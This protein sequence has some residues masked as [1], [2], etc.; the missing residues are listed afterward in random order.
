MKHSA[1]LGLASLCLVGWLGVTPG[2]A[3]AAP[4][5]R[6]TPG[7][8]GSFEFDTGAVRGKLREDG[9]SKGLTAVIDRRTGSRI[10][11]GA[12]LFGHYRLFSANRRYGSAAWDLP[13][14]ASLQPDGSV[15]VVWPRSDQTPFV[16]GA[17]Y[18]WKSATALEVETSVTAQGRLAL[19]ESFLASYFAPGFTNSWVYGKR[20]EAGSPTWIPARVEAGVWQSFAR[21]PQAW[22]IIRDGRWKLEPNPVEWIEQPNFSCPLGIRRSPSEGICVALMARAADC[23]A[24][25][26]PHETEPHRSMYLSL[27]GR[28]VEPGQTVVARARLVLINGEAGAALKAYEDFGSEAK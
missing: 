22:K 14:E 15:K 9:K 6:F 12:G 21:E 19:F 17:V 27:F 25:S 7:A 18:R 16:L 26:T 13:S 24:I 4:E 11:A 2:T 5:L 20:L 10:D 8:N 1:K 28:D 23:F 3:T